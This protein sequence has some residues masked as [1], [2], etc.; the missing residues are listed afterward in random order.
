MSMSPR[1][2]W[3]TTALAAALIAAGCGGESEG[4]GGGNPLA[5]R[6]FVSESVEGWQ[7]VPNTQVWLSFKDTALGAN[8]GC[9]SIDAEYQLAGNQLQIGGYGQ[10]EMGCD[11]ARGAQDDWLIAFLT[12]DPM[13]E[14]NE[15]R[16]ILETAN[17]RMILLDREVASPDR[18]LV[19]TQ[20]IG[21][22]IGDGSSVQAGPGMSAI[23]IR[24]DSDGTSVVHTGCQTGSGA[25]QVQGT[26]ITFDGL[27]Y[28]GTPCSDPNLESLS[29]RALQVLDGS[30]VSFETDQTRL[31]I[32]NDSNVIHFRAQE[33]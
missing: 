25:Y 10:T 6:V 19:G 9:N 33:P 1:S 30:A 8:A 17:A 26:T 14:M 24:F 12:A 15:P 20:W 7:L 18:P 31:K 13:F 5:G 23:D 4:P 21:E 27:V 3:R 11:P 16:L 32:R 2:G 22:A 28:D 29:N